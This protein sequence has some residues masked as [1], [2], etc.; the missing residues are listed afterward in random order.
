MCILFA[1]LPFIDCLKLE[2]CCEEKGRIDVNDMFSVSTVC[3][4]SCMLGPSGLNM[5]GCEEYFAVRSPAN[6]IVTVFV[7]CAVST[8]SL[9]TY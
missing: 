9:A 3:Y 1:T 4:S 7:D 5:V 2:L 6:M 8:S